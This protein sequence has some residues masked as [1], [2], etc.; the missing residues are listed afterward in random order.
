MIDQ[1]S[2]GI[3]IVEDDEEI[4]DLLVDCLH[5]EGYQVRVAGD[6]AQALA[7]LDEWHPDCIVLDLVMP[8]MNG[9]AFRQRQREDSRIADIPVVLI[10]GVQA[11]AAAAELG[12]AAGIQ[13]PFAIATFLET[14]GSVTA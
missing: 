5:E 12:T 7:V 2:R 6:G 11:R 14:V 4:R 8:V 1:H 9:R 10:S 13:K 3:L